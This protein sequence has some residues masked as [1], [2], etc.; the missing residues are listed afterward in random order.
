VSVFWKIKKKERKRKTEKK[1]GKENVPK[2]ERKK[3]SAGIS[4]ILQRI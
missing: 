3:C 2:K 1:K 4:F